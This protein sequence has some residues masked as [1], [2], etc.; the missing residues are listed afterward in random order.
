MGA[1][2]GTNAVVCPAPDQCHDAG[3]CN[4]GTGACSNPAKPD[5]SACSDGNACTRTDACEGGVCMGGNSVVCPAPD[6][7]HDAGTCNPGTG[8]CSNPAKPDGSACNDGNACTQTDTCERGVCTGSNL[9]VCPVPDQCHDAGTC[10][11]ATGACSNPGKPDGT[12]CND[13]NACTQTDTCQ[14]GV[15]AGTNAVVCTAQDQCHDAGT[16]NP[17]NGTCSNPAKPDGSACTDGN[18]CTRTDAC[19]SGACTGGNPVVCPAPD[20]CHDAGTCNPATGAC[21]NPGRPDGTTCHD[22]NACTQTDVCQAGVCTGTNA[23]VCTAQDQCH[24]TGTCNPATGTCSNPVKFEGA[25][26]DDGNPCTIAD[27]C[28]A[29]VCIG[30]ALPGCCLDDAACDDAI[31]C[32]DDR[33]VARACVHVPVDERC[34]PRQDCAV[35]VCTPSD[36]GAGASGCILRPV[37]DEVFCTED[38][39]PCTADTCRGGSCQHASAGGGD[40]QALAGPFQSMLSLLALDD[41]LRDIVAAAAASACPTL[42]LSTSCA[43]VSGTSSPAPRLLALVDGARADLQAAVLGLGGRLPGASVADAQLRARLALGL[44]AGTP[45][46]MRA[47]VAT[48]AQARGRRLI[49]PAFARARQTEARALLRATLRLRTDLRRILATRRSFAR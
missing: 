46:K 40:C 20:Q 25:V 9:V 33:C 44:F 34:G 17:G 32:T 7:C 48:A 24:D 11:P 19:Q 45:G 16:C 35:P 36:P 47:F 49:A 4:P 39:D 43:L 31:T 27:G 30:T 21:S 12:T 18:A 3:T 41:G 23:V 13:G 14:R 42:A 8:T 6:Q 26:C 37:D 22:G 10:N 28:H 2:T 5:G 1:C 38:G 29:S 15:C